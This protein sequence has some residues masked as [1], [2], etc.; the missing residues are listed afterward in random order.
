MKREDKQ[1]T[2]LFSNETSTQRKFLFIDYLICFCLV[3]VFECRLALDGQMELFWHFLKSLDG[4][5]IKRQTAIYLLKHDKIHH[6]SLGIRGYNILQVLHSQ[7]ILKGM[8]VN[9]TNHILFLK[10]SF[11]PLW[12]AHIVI[13][14]CQSQGSS[15]T[16]D[17]NHKSVQSQFSTMNIV[18]MI[19]NCPYKL[20]RRVP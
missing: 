2:K 14:F 5:K 15:L 17:A 11:K 9:S 20:K 7:F 19:C 8:T 10:I 18:C 4:Q 13:S 12:F 6:S 3:F 16:D 1:K